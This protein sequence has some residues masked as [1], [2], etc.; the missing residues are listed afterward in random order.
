[1][2][3]SPL[4]DLSFLVSQI[5][6]GLTAFPS[7]GLEDSHVPQ[8]LRCRFCLRLAAFIR[9]C[10][11]RRAAS[12]LPDSAF[13]CLSP[14]SRPGFFCRPLKYDP[15]LKRMPLSVTLRDLTEGPSVGPFPT[16]CPLVHTKRWT[17][18]P[19]SA[20]INPASPFGLFCPVDPPFERTH[21][22]KKRPPFV[23]NSPFDCQ[24]SG[25]DVE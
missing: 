21:L 20:F 2:E 15:I 25:R 3:T 13:F 4:F 18:T 24:V 23:F 8:H 10:S 9:R 5:V 11:P 22:P 17:L 19:R 7:V 14:K 1:V 12:V 6:S 16:S